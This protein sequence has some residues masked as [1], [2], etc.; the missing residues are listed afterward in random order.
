M[1]VRKAK[2]QK[3]HQNE[4]PHKCLSEQHFHHTNE[5]LPHI[6]PGEGRLP[7]D[8]HYWHSPIYLFLLSHG[9]L[10]QMPLLICLPEPSP[11]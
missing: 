10:Q 4:H 8:F 3:L 2:W 1:P 5:Y 7:Q 6:S 9:V 11:G